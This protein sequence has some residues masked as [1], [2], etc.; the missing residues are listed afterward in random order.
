MGQHIPQ[1]RSREEEARFWDSVDLT[2]LAPDQLEEIRSASAESPRSTTFA[3]R[4][5]QRTVHLVRSMAKSSGLGPTQLVRSWILERLRLEIEAGKLIERQTS[6]YPLEF[7]RA[8]RHSIVES[9]ISQIPSVA[10]RVLSEVLERAD[11]EIPYFTS[12][13]E[14]ERGAPSASQ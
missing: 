14:Q 7:E 4:L 1:F 3:V 13:S 8:L 5:D 2:D 11:S 9:L 10:E 6:D 12:S